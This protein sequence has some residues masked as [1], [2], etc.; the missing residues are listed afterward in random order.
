[1]T[2]GTSAHVGSSLPQSLRS[3]AHAPFTDRT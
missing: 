3:W 2:V 1:M